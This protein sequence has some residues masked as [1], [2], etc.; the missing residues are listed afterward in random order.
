MTLIAQRLVDVTC[1]CGA[2]LAIPQTLF[3]EAHRTGRG[4]YCPAT[5]H[6]FGWDS[7]MEKLRKERDQA[8]AR[9][10]ALNDQLLAEQGAHRATKATLTKE[11]KR[12][13]HGVCPCCNRSFV[14]V[15]RHMKTKHPDYVAQ[16]AD[17]RTP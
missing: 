2:P 17:I 9:A 16:T 14:N 3:D 5:G 11:R 10:T 15:G 8:K 4:L 7:E 13:A 1:W 12:A 6:R